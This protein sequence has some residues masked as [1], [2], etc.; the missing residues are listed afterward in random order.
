MSLDE[1]DLDNISLRVENAM[2]KAFDRHRTD[3]H[4]PLKAAI[5]KEIGDVNHRINK[6]NQ[7]VWTGNGIMLTIAA[8]IVWIKN[9]FSK[10]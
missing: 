10:Q 6:T 4:V 3:D 8:M 1:N 2:W 9:P 7:M 5:D